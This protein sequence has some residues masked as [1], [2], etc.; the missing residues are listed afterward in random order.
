MQKRVFNVLTNPSKG[1]L[2]ISSA[3]SEEVAYRIYNLSGASCKSKIPVRSIRSS[4]QHN[5]HVSKR[6]LKLNCYTLP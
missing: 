3:S 5:F 2:N 6:N 4:F 1:I